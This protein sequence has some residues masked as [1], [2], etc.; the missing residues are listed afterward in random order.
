MRTSYLFAATALLLPAAA[1]AQ[2]SD[3]D[4]CRA[5]TQ[6]YQTL[7]ES[8]ERGHNPQPPPVDAQAAIEQCKAGNT[9][10]GIPV[11]EQ[12]LRNAKVDL[13]KRS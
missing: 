10:A 4:Y 6:R 1:F 12:K 5:L 8:V 3:A 11:L 2:M 9:A 7:V 13:P